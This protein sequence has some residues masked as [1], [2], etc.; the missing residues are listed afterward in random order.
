MER[1]QLTST[2]PTEIAAL[3]KLVFLDLDFN[4]LTGILTPELF[5]LTNLE[6]LDL[7]N[8]QLRGP[9][10]GIGV[11]P[12]MVFLQLH[13]NRFSGTVL[14]EIGNFAQLEVFTLHETDISGVM[15][16]SVCTLLNSQLDSL[17]ADCQGN[18]RD[19]ECP[20]CTDCRLNQ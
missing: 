16:Q 9:I 2:I 8:N 14:A 18:N 15:P 20:C 19:I 13:D 11:F 5:S 1:G 10:D 3:S 12:N 4:E 6:Q 7:N 17:I